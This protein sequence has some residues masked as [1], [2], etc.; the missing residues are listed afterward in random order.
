MNVEFSNNKNIIINNN[1]IEIIKN[2][3]NQWTNIPTKH[4][5]DIEHINTSLELDPE[6]TNTLRNYLRQTIRTYREKNIILIVYR[7]DCIK[8]ILPEIFSDLN[9][10]TI[11]LYYNKLKYSIEI[12]NLTKNII[13]KLIENIDN[14]ECCICFE[15]GD[16]IENCDIC[17]VNYC[18]NC[19]FSYIHHKFD[20]HEY[21][22]IVKQNNYI[23]F[24][25]TICKNKS[26]EFEL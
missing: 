17:F 25:C 3:I 7:T 22:K 4:I 1:I 10:K 15:K 24:D 20:D 2:N 16:F 14:K 21:I 8:S 12:E 13:L 19:F 9:N 5:F 6:E 26:L 11:I 18:K 23:Y